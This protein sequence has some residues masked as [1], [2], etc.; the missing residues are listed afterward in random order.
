[1]VEGNQECKSRVPL[2]IRL[3][4]NNPPA[5]GIDRGGKALIKKQKEKAERD[6]RSV[7]ICIRARQIS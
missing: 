1:M 5:I 3:Y 4:Y 2:S 6:D 7:S